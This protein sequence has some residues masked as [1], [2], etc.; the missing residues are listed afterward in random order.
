MRRTYKMINGKLVESVKV[1]RR[2]FHNI[3]PDIKPYWSVASNR[4]IGSRSKRREDLKVTGCRGV[5]PGEKK[6]FMKQPEHEE[7]KFNQEDLHR[8]DKI[9]RDERMD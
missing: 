1:Q 9:M 3:Q 6:S 8:I 4:M 2:N 7:F 5:D